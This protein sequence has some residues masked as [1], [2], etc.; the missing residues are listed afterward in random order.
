MKS[1]FRHLIFEYL[2]HKQQREV[3]IPSTSGIQQMVSSPKEDQSS[4]SDCSVIEMLLGR[5]PAP[6]FSSSASS[7]SLLSLSSSSSF[8]TT[9]T[10]SLSA[11]MKRTDE[12]TDVLLLSRV[13][14]R[15]EEDR[16]ESNDLTS[17]SSSLNILDRLKAAIRQAQC[18]DDINRRNT[19]ED[20][21]IAVET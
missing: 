21:R 1:S 6:H 3:S 15:G 11:P 16:E 19:S 20:C 18:H 13:E 2:P 9:I 12:K 5:V 17:A 14:E 7:P 10:N 4:S 8:T